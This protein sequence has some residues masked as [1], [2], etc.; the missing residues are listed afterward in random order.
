MSDSIPIY[1]RI[2]PSN[3]PTNT[4][5]TDLS[6]HSIQ[7]DLNSLIQ[8]SEN[9]NTVNNTKTMYSYQ[10]NKIYGMDADQ[11]DLF[12][13]LGQPI[14]DSGFEGFNGCLFAYGQSG[15]GKTF[16]IS[17][18]T[19]KYS[20]RGLIPRSIEYL[21]KKINEEQ[22]SNIKFRVSISYVEIYNGTCF[23]L[24]GG[25]SSVISRL[26]DL[27]KVSIQEDETGEMHFLNLTT[28]SVSNEEEALNLLFTGDT[29]RVVAETPLNDVSTRSHCVFIMTL[30]SRI[31]DL[32]RTAKI[33]FVDLAGSERVSRTHV[34]GKILAESRSINQSLH[35]L[36]QVIVALYE[37]SKGIRNH[38]PYRNSVLTSILRDSIGGNSKTE[39]LA[40]IN[41]NEQYIDESISTCRFAQRVAQI[42]NIPVINEAQDPYVII[43]GLKSQV[44]KLTEEL[45]VLKGDNAD[46]TLTSE[47]KAS[48]RSKVTDYIQHGGELICGSMSKIRAAFSIFRDICL[49]SGHKETMSTTREQAH[50][51]NTNNLNNKKQPIP[52]APPEDPHTNPTK[53]EEITGLPI[54]AIL[55]DAT[56]AYEAFRKVTRVAE[57]SESD[58]QLLKSLCEEGKTVGETGTKARNEVARL[59]QRLESLRMY[60]EMNDNQLDESRED[61]MQLKLNIDEHMKL[62]NKSTDRLKIIKSDIDRIQLIANQNK[63]KIQQDFDIWFGKVK[64]R[65]NGEGIEKNSENDQLQ[66]YYRLRDEILNSN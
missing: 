39:M 40:C 2:R 55:L 18:G 5:K 58:K 17:G 34:E 54:L 21:Y 30:E 48:L 27:Q 26:S 65:Y 19:E 38:I 45:A 20:D 28:N 22:K 35:F 16:S 46:D 33:H 23:D 51:E 24:L 50:T 63:H 43:S 60:E 36:E 7:F 64:D 59:K 57:I 32:V 4:A 3:N 31:G 44:A 6:T 14:I 41:L 8:T 37:K 29:N 12:V 9:S 1:L 11:D 49:T 10:F 62:Y 13:T 56:K 61:C 15:S 66:E 53:I 47:E 52:N 25:S 42:K